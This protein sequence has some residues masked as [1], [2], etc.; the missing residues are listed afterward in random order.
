[1]NSLDWVAEF[2]ERAKAIIQ[3]RRRCWLWH[4]YVWDSEPFVG[5]RR[6]YSSP[7]LFQMGR[8]RCGRL[9]QRELGPARII[10]HR[11]Q[12]IATAQLHDD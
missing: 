9:E 5:L 11:G 8:C 2:R 12:K 7:W 1:M 3:R 10:T 6:G 4:R